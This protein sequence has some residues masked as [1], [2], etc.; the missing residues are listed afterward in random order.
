M[1]EVPG[2]SL[3]RSEYGAAAEIPQFLPNPSTGQLIDLRNPVDVATALYE[4]RLLE[5]KLR[6]AKAMLG[7]VLAAEAQRRGDTTMHLPGF[8]VPVSRKVEITWDMGVL[9]E[10]KKLGLPNDRWQE[11]VKV[12]VEEKV[13]A[14]EAKKIA[15]ANPVYAEVIKR[16]RRDWKGDPTVGK[17]ERYINDEVS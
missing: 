15:A 16:A 14:N 8:K 1:S 7:R 6:A 2:G 17:I 13:S 9:L 11:L 5:D 10:L 3:E 12:T 4:I